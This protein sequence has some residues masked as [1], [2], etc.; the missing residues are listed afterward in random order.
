[1][2]E[3]RFEIELTPVEESRSRHRPAAP[4]PLDPNEPPDAP[5]GPD[6]VVTVGRV[7]D[8]AERPTDRWFGSERGRL[9]TAAAVAA[10]VAL[11]LGWMLGRA[12]SGGDTATDDAPAVSSPADDEPEDV[13]DTTFLSGDAIPPVRTTRPLPGNTSIRNDGF[14]VLIRALARSA[15]RT[16]A[17]IRITSKTLLQS[18]VSRKLSFASRR[19]ICSMQ[20]ATARCSLFDIESLP[21]ASR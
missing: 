9:V 1:M 16:W 7:G 11:L 12:G 17:E 5:D 4:E 3:D 10:S 14:G 20:Y 8:G 18:S 13:P 6:G 21:I 15:E 2:E 19:F